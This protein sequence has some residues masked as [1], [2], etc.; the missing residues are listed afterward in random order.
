MTTRRLESK[1][2]HCQ[3]CPPASHHSLAAGDI[4][5][6]PLFLIRLPNDDENISA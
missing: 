5:L 3:F 1:G 6:R 4:A 2:E